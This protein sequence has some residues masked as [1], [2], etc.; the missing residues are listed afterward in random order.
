MTCKW[1]IPMFLAAVVVVGLAPSV[2]AQVIISPGAIWETTGGG[3]AGFRAP[4]NM[5]ASGIGRADAM[6]PNPLAPTQITETASVS[7]RTQVIVANLETFFQ[8]LNTAVVALHNI[9]LARAGRSPV[10]PS[11]VFTPSSSGSL[12]PSTSG[13]SDLTDL[14][15]QFSTLFN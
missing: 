10:I 5:V 13:G 15:D 2:E 1:T 4:G 8:T 6:M 3:S 14:I 12:A 9:I 11:S 7:L